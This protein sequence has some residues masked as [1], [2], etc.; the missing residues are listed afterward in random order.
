MLAVK[1]IHHSWK[2]LQPYLDAYKTKKQYQASKEL[3]SK[4]MKLPKKEK[5]EEMISFAKI[6]ARQIA[7]YEENLY[8]KINAE[9]KEILRYLMQLHNLTQ[10]DFPEIGGQSLI[11]KILKGEREL[12]RSHINYLCKRFNIS[13]ETFF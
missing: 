4:L 13:P 12:T 1:E 11:S 5:T 10:S 2:V 6:L 9:P 8:G 7:L 3:L